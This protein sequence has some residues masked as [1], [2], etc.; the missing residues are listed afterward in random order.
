MDYEFLRSLSG[1]I[2][3]VF[4]VASFFGFVLYAF[5]P[6]SKRVHSDSAEIP[7]RHDDAPAPEAGQEAQQ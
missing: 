2:G 4:L 1:S 3:T 5:R 6:G 7:F